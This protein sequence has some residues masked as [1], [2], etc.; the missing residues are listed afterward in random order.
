MGSAEWGEL[1]CGPCVLGGYAFDD[2][3]GFEG[4][5]IGRVTLLVDHGAGDIEADSFLDLTAVGGFG[6]GE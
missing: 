1:P 3:K 4:D 5:R 2:A 6:L